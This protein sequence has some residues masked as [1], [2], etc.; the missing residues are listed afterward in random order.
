MTIK[1]QAYLQGYLHEKTAADPNWGPEDKSPSVLRPRPSK[2]EQTDPN[3]GPEDRSP[4]RELT[5]EALERL[6]SRYPR[7]DK[8]LLPRRHVR[9]GVE[10]SEY[11]PAQ[12][13][14]P[15][16]TPSRGGL[17]GSEYGPAQKP[18]PSYTPSR[19]GL[20]GSE[21]GPVKPM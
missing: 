6:R 11:G 1:P 16:Y 2:R 9:P 10:G 20:E 21:Y 17:E 4:A 12:K 19:G 3:W 18:M 15:S 13:P 5:P 8:T 14:M 7:P